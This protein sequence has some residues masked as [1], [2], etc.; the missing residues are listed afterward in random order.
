MVERCRDAF[1]VRMMCRL[2]GVSASGYYDWRSRPLSARAQ[3]NEQLLG[4]IRSLHAA[5][6][7]VLGR[8]RL[9]DD[10]LEEGERCSPNRVGRLMQRAGLK[11]IPQRK[12]WRSKRSGTRPGDVENHLARDFAAAAANRK[13]VTDI[14]FIRTVESWLYLCVV[15]DLYSR[16]VVGWSMST[17]QDRQL[18]LQA[19]LMALWQ[20][21][22]REPVFLHSDRGCQFTSD[23]YQRFLRGHNLIC[24]MSAVGSCADNALAEGFFGMLKRERVNRRRYLTPAEARADVFDYIE[25]FHN[26][27]M[28]RRL[29]IDERGTVGLNSSVRETGA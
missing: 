11:G 2:L 22:D 4:R 12:R 20:R 23:E 26:P 21:E 8:R 3:A 18:V 17:V 25:R 1:K 6:D 24:S 28:R 9:Y 15:I 5:S 19:V 16:L 27:R 29:T 7:G 10:L 14:T 13:W